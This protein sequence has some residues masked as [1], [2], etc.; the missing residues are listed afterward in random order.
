M[1]NSKKKFLFNVK[2]YI[3]TGPLNLRINEK[4]FYSH[5]DKKLFNIHDI[6][7]LLKK[8]KIY[9]IYV[10]DSI[11]IQR[12]VDKYFE[13][14]KN[15][16]Y[17]I[18]EFE[19]I[20]LELHFNEIKENNNLINS[21]KKINNEII[22]LNSKINKVS[23]NIQEYDLIYLYASPF[24]KDDEG[25]SLT[26][27][28]ISY[29]E[30]INTILKI[31]KR[32]KKGFK[33]LFKCASL[34][35]LK[36]V[37]YNKKTKVLHIS[38]HGEIDQNGFNLILENLDKYGIEQKISKNALENIVIDNANKIKSIDLIILSNCYSG[39]FKNI[40]KANSSPQYTI[41]VKK[42]YQIN[43]LVCVLFCEHF[44]SE[45]SDG[46]SI[47]KSFE[48][49]INK[50]K[51]DSRLS[52]ITK[53][54][55]EINKLKIFSNSKNFLGPYAFNGKGK[56]SINRNVKIQ[57]DSKKY[58]S[59]I[60]RNE[61]IMKV[62]QD[63]K[64]NKNKILIIYGSKG[65]EKLDFMESLGVYLFERKIIYDYEIYIEAEIDEDIL[66]KI[67][68]KIEE[69]QQIINN[70]KKKYIFI[71]QIEGKEELKIIDKLNKIKEI[72]NN[73]E[74]F[75]FIIL[76]DNKYL[77]EKIKEIINYN[78]FNAL[79]K[80][81]D[82]KKL[83]KELL[84]YY[85][86]K[87][88]D[89]QLELCLK[90]A[91]QNWES[92]ISKEDL[93]VEEEKFLILNNEDENDI[94]IYEH[95]TI[96]KIVDLFFL[97]NDVNKINLAENNNKVDMQ[98][99]PECAYLFLLSKMP[100]GLPDCFIQL[101]FKRKFNHNLIGK[102]SKNKWN[103]INTD[104]EFTR[105]QNEV[106]TQKDFEKNNIRYFLEALKLYT[107][108]LYYYIEK[109]RDK[110]LYPNEN[111]HFVFNS[112]NNK[113]IWKSNIQNI[114]DENNIKENDF[115][116]DDFNVK[117]HRENI[118][119]LI[120]YLVVRLDYIKEEDY[121]YID[122]LVEILLLFPSFFFLKKIC[123]K[124][125]EKCKEFCSICIKYFE[126]YKDKNEF[127]KKF[128]FQKA[129]LSLFLYS[130]CDTEI[131][132]ENDFPDDILLQSELELLKFL[133]KGDKND[134]NSIKIFEKFVEDIK[135]K[136]I[137]NQ[138]H[139]IKAKRK[140]PKNEI[141]LFSPSNNLYNYSYGEIDLI[142][143][144]FYVLG[145]SY[146]KLKNFDKSEKY[147]NEAYNALS[148]SERFQFLETR[149]KIDLCYILLNKIKLERK[150]I[151][152]IKE[153][154]IEEKINVL[155]MLL[156]E[157]FNEKLYYEEFH[158]KQ[159]FSNLLKPNI[160]MLNSNPLNN[161]YS[162]FS[163]GIYAYPNNQY[164]ILEELR[165]I[166]K[167]KIKSHI[168]LKTY[169]L[170]KQN[171]IEALQKKPEVLIIQSDDFTENGDIMMESDEGISEK[172]AVKEF[173]E[174][175]GQYKNE[176]KFKIVL[177]CF[178]NS[179][180]LFESIKNEIEYEYLIY[181]KNIKNIYSL[182]EE[183]LIEIN[184][185]SIE[186]I[187]KLISSYNENI[188]E[189]IEIIDKKIFEIN[190]NFSSIDKS[191]FEF[192][193]INNSTVVNTKN[194]YI[195]E[196]GIFF[197]DPFLEIPKIENSFKNYEF[198]YYYYKGLMNDKIREIIKGK[199]ANL[200]IGKSQREKY[201]KFGFEII[202]Y[203]YRHNK[204]NQYYY[205]DLEK[206]REIEL[207]TKKENEIKIR[208]TRQNK[209]FYFI[210]NNKNDDDAKEIINTIIN[211][212]N[213]IN[214]IIINE[215]EDYFTNEDNEY[216]N[217]NLINNIGNK[218]NNNC[219]VYINEV[220]FSESDSEDYNIEDEID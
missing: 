116:D 30:E 81:D 156:Y 32:K 56:L 158:L 160:I 148:F 103:Y 213:Y 80:K 18:D 208:K 75:Y 139:Y 130:I 105:N 64:N 43:D 204:F 135:N 117:K 217:K 46:K 40:F 192:Y 128:K 125:I 1:K 121:I 120:S 25:H 71:I 189:S 182:S 133:K 59:M 155:D 199:G 114:Q 142:I 7:A 137:S 206:D 79:L 110:I 8:E 55:T 131:K 205:I 118:Y 151:Q 170:N 104:I 5:L 63:I 132:D 152:E 183:K 124:Y 4:P 102:Y 119:N 49:A 83:F 141:L 35:V 61:I 36:E 29:R 178:I 73:K 123:R 14:M 2:Y 126:Q 51:S 210:Y 129:K 176:L 164:Y 45:L 97:Y 92:K 174:I 219:S 54:D 150:E 72:S 186:S 209:N 136:I 53:K 16:I 165:K 190:Y 115:I 57:F 9:D 95:K 171:L 146:F 203:F 211:N 69:I 47:N 89:D 44:Y 195:R 33:C 78:C 10:I 179:S 98:L 52:S 145:R 88:N 218:E 122:Y 74:Y 108:I 214:Y 169:V 27:G 153:K 65:S 62:L 41:Y 144:L 94:P 17:T 127:L 173:K 113:G 21:Y 58:K 197:S 202:K 6:Y 19:S 38:S 212:P 91:K 193:E 157:N 143:I 87:M 76:I 13:N 149:I 194:N 185:Y 147:L 3:T 86:C 31:M 181:F 90:K 24:F 12:K 70:E 26:K 191:Y 220:S 107:K 198:N 188:N 23:E 175:I 161:G 207:I 34:D 77:S 101:I 28:K 172:L 20:V 111:F 37:L 134:N 163:S 200:S 187:I 177:L 50:L 138:K 66:E 106:I 68:L 166:K 99:T 42:K 196:K 22:K 201:K 84:S 60:G 180:K 154:D 159:K 162:I 67:E 168:R 167:G 109:D 184:K 39:G 215:D 216:N 85:G 48:N 93:E 15:K 140:T 100:K 96:S 112:Y 11:K 82:A